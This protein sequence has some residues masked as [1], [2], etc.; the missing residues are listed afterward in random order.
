VGTIEK[1]VSSGWNGADCMRRFWTDAEI[2]KVVELYPGTA[3][4]EIAREMGCGISRIYN[5]AFR[6]GLKKSAAYLSSPEASRFRRGYHSGREYRF[7]KGHV[8]N[9]KGLRRP[10]WG[11]GRMKET[12]F[13]RGE[14]KGVAAV[15]WQPLGTISKDSEGFLRIKVRD[16]RPGEHTGFGN[17]KVWPL[18]NRYTWE[19]SNGPIP[20][21]HAI[22]FKDGNRDNCEI[23]NL[24]LVSRRELMLR[25]TVHKL[26]KELAQIIQ[27]RGALNRKIRSLSEE[28][29]V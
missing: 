5:L 25:N 23:A 4:N 8:P 11:P 7:P 2:A 27:L 18:L 29:N 17:V 1:D 9:N 13:K 12:Q 16:A 3:T 22:C 15:N 14:R 10:G 6:L 26:P 28:Q 19:Q 24:E 21:G 20:P